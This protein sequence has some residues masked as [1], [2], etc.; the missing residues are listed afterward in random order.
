MSGITTVITG[1]GTSLPDGV[2]GNDDV[3]ALADAGRLRTFVDTNSWCRQRCAH[4]RSNGSATDETTALDRRVF[5]EFVEQRVGIL[6]RRV[7]DREAV[8]ARRPSVSGR[9]GS[10]LGAEA[11]LRAVGDAGLVADDV[12]VVILGSSTPDSLCPAGAVVIQEAIGAHRAFAFDVQAAC[13]SFVFAVAA[14]RGFLASGQ[15]RRALVVAAEQF[16]AMTDWSEPSTSYFAGDGAAA[17]VLEA[18]GSDL[19]PPAKPPRWELVDTLCWSTYSHNIR[20][21]VGG[22][23]V[24]SAWMDPVAAARATPGQDGYRYF[25]QNGPQVYRDVMPE[26]DAS[27]RTLLARHGLEPADVARWWVHQASRP[28]IEGI[29]QRLLGHM[30]PPEV[31]PI[32]LE[33]LGNTS[34]CGAAY[35][36][37]EDRG[38]APGEHGVLLVFGGGYTVGAVL[39]RGR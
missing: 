17:V 14:A 13:S 22:T 12:D 32:V 21:G 15:A 36:L 19:P 39:L 27:S 31:A 7:V 30:P 6:E 10:T 38:L 23:R 35:C 33:R 9:W 8:L 37:A 24:L 20:T 11:A 25:H 16:S 26:V 18:I 3:A 28:M 1:R 5:A 2:L 29:F 4:L 34:A